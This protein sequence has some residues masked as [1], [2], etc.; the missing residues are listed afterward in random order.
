M[1]LGVYLGMT[2]ASPLRAAN[3]DRKSIRLAVRVAST[4]FGSLIIVFLGAT[5]IVIRTRSGHASSGY[6]PPLTPVVSRESIDYSQNSPITI[7]LEQAL[8]A[9]DAELALPADRTYRQL[10]P[11]RSALKIAQQIPRDAPPYARALKAIAEA[12]YDTGRTLLQQA[13]GMHP[14]IATRIAMTSSVL[15]VY[16]QRFSE[17]T[18]FTDS[19][20]KSRPDDVAALNQASIAQL[21]AGNFA[22]AEK[23]AVKAVI[24]KSASSQR[25][26][27]LATCLDTL[28]TVRS[29]QGR[30]REAS[31]GYE[32]AI[33]VREGV[34]ATDDAANARSY[35][36]LAMVYD[37]MGRYEHAERLYQKALV[38]IRKKFGSDSAE[39]ATCMNNLAGHYLETRRYSDAESLFRSALDI[40]M[41]VLGARH[42]DT[43]QTLNNLAGLYVE[44]G[45]FRQ[46]AELFGRVLD[47]QIAI[48]G[49]ESSETAQ[50]LDN[51]AG[52]YARQRR[53]KEA[54]AV[55]SRELGIRRKLLGDHHPDIAITLNNIACMY[56]NRGRLS[57][58]DALFDEALKIDEQAFGPQAT[59]VADVCE[60]YAILRYKQGRRA[61][62]RRLQARARRI[63][64]GISR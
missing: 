58:A 9:S 60:N 20:L 44:M 51:I 47:T 32:Q 28:A 1:R 63:H 26:L 7:A 5:I 42:V 56:T 8:S 34:K 15:E 53:Y 13:A 30:L 31:E 14:E 64:L 49:A 46:A 52:L 12:Q 45:D 33:S 6:L 40:Q 29:V 36:R 22:A 3:T 19:I 43:L 55:Y 41:K 50:T 4:V 37:A 39:S 17:A 62:G 61:D 11:P 10:A 2:D 48:L 18:R 21:D 38:L 24:L 27:Q 16:A 57:D 59:Q 25:S 54:D 35:N 23:T